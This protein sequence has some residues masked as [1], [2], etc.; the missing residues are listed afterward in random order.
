MATTPNDIH[1]SH[2]SLPKDK[3]Q[4]LLLEGI[5]SS[6]IQ[7][8]IHNGYTNVEAISTALP[9]EE[10]KK[11][12]AQAHI[13]GIRSRTQLTEEVLATAEKLM[14][15]GC[16][17]IGTNQVD[18]DAAAIHGIPRLQCSLLQHAQCR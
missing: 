3:I 12:I 1:T 8:F 5:H 17:C 16:F 13:V 7:H 6:A 14:A 4:I 2:F 10:L 18:L 15:I 11:K 9:T